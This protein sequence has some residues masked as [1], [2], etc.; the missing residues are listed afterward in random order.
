MLKRVEGWGGSGLRVCARRGKKREEDEGEV[1]SRGERENEGS[2]MHS[3][4]RTNER[5]KRLTQRTMMKK[6]ARK[7]QTVAVGSFIVQPL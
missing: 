5:R 4:V 6:K 2:C 1:S 7:T 3:P